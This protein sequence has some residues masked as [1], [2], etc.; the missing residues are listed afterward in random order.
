[1]AP[2]WVHALAV[3]T[4]LAALPLFFLG[5]DVTTKGAGMA[6]QRSVVPFWQAIGEM[7]R[8]GQSHGWMIEHLHRL[9]GWFI[10]LCGIA[11]TVSLWLTEPRR[12]VRWLGTAALVLIIVQGL[13]GIFRIQ[14]HA[15][16]GPNLAWVHGS[17][18]PIVLGTLVAV[19][20]VTSRAWWRESQGGADTT[21][22]R[23]Q[24]VGTCVLIYVQLVVG[25]MVRH[26]DF[27]LGARL[28]VL[29]AFGVTVAVLW[30]VKRVGERGGAEWLVWVLVGLLGAQVALG[31]EAWISR[32][33]L[34]ESPWNQVQ[35]WSPRPEILRT[36]HF[37]GGAFLFATAVALTLGLYRP[38]KRIAAQEE[39]EIQEKETEVLV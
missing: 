12:W 30:L 20:G 34:P 8:G 9:A 33:H 1:M 29:L 6:D 4:V 23:K 14:L 37:V 18:A 11:L 25:G 35:P 17:F 3:V 39:T 5:A 22:L 38:T 21:A 31:I 24:G 2:R 15:L 10:G 36:L 7:P 27:F 28:H 26:Q 13:L 16:L 32:F 19:A